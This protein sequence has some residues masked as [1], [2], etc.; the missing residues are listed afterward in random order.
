M[1]FQHEQVRQLAIELPG[2]IAVFHRHDVD[3]TAHG[4]MTLGEALMQVPPEKRAAINDDLAGLGDTVG[5]EVASADL[6]RHVLGPYH[7]TQRAE[8]MNAILIARSVERRYWDRSECPVGLARALKGLNEDLDL[9]Q[10]SEESG[11]FR[12]LCDNPAAARSGSIHAMMREHAHMV[13]HLES[14]RR[15]AHNYV[16]PDDACPEWREL[17]AACRKLDAD[18]RFHVDLEDNRLFPRFISA[19]AAAS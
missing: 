14:I 15:L 18:L 2:A 1:I 10:I 4:A 7:A 6:I 8:F 12:H 16:A 9:H 5:G 19:Q 11:L 3:F 13:R 17:Y